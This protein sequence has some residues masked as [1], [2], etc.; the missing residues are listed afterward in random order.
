MAG[1]GVLLLRERLP[2]QYGRRLCAVIHGADGWLGP[3][4][5]RF[6]LRDQFNRL[7]AARLRVN[8]ERLGNNEFGYACFELRFLVSRR[9]K[10]WWVRR[11]LRTVAINHDMAGATDASRYMV[12]FRGRKSWLRRRGARCGDDFGG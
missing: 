4:G 8:P 10:R 6:V 5:L 12:L 2:G 9:G 11:R 3:H 7:F 1:D